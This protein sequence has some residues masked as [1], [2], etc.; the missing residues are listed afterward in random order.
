[1]SALIS[2][3]CAVPRLGYAA[4]FQRAK[5][6]HAAPL[7]IP[8]TQKKRI[9]KIGV[10]LVDTHHQGLAYGPDFATMDVRRQTGQRARDLG[11]FP[12]A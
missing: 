4:Q 12:Q 5:L 3:T 10:V 2:V 11:A 9:D 6:A 8:L 7:G 1:L